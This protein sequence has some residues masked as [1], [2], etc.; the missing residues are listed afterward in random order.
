MSAS[1]GIMVLQPIVFMI[2]KISVS[3][4]IRHMILRQFHSKTF[5]DKNKGNYLQSFFYWNFRKEI[6]WFWFASNLICGFLC[7]LSLP[8]S[9]IYLILWVIGH[10]LLFPEIVTV[11]AWFISLMYS[12]HFISSFIYFILYGRDKK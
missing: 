12:V 9:M 1:Y 8:I 10:V 7:I 3:Y 11:V 2:L 4:H 6:N 5:I